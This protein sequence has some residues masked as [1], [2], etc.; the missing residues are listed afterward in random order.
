MALSQLKDYQGLH[1]LL[2]EI[3]PLHSAAALPSQDV[4]GNDLCISDNGA[5]DSGHL[6]PSLSIKEHIGDE[7][8]RYFHYI[9]IEP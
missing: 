9:R 7:R 3:I 1:K 2:V 4:W 8:W 5:V 6:E